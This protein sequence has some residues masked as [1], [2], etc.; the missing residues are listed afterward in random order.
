MTAFLRHSK[1][2]YPTPSKA[3]IEAFGK[4]AQKSRSVSAVLK[5]QQS[6]KTI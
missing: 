3:E 1:K 5:K 2:I 4:K 6:Q